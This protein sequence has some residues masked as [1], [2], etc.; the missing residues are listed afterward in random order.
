MGPIAEELGFCDQKDRLV[1]RGLSENLRTNPQIFT[2]L[3]N[4]EIDNDSARVRRFYKTENGDAI[5]NVFIRYRQE[6]TLNLVEEKCS[7]SG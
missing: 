1:A 2:S 3:E 5:L 6:S 7:I 4:I